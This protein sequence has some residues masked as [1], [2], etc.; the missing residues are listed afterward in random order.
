MFNFSVLVW[1]EWFSRG[2]KKICEIYQWQL[3]KHGP[4]LWIEKGTLFL[5][6]YMPIIILFTESNP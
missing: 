4:I 6:M 5:N 1:I 3:S 2:I